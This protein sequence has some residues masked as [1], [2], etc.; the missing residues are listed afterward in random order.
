MRLR[1]PSGQRGEPIDVA[2]KV[3]ECSVAATGSSRVYLLRAQFLLGPYLTDEDR[4]S[5]I[6]Y[7][8]QKQRLQL[9]ARRHLK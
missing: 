5:I 3:I 7:I 6:A 4:D 8:F 9:R 1:V 2:A